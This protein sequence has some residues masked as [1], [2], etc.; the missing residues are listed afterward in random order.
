MTT[1]IFNIVKNSLNSSHHNIDH[2]HS[3]FIG[4]QYKEF[5]DLSYEGFYESIEKINQGHPVFEML[6]E[7]LISSDDFILWDQPNIKQCLQSILN[8]L[9]V[10]R[11]HQSKQLEKEMAIKKGWF[12]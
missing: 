9:G 12:V 11:V 10:Y 8:E 2:K 4:N 6:E 3:V 1:T 7:K 5:F